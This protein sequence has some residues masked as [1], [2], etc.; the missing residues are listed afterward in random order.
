MPQFPG[1]SQLSC[2]HCWPQVTQLTVPQNLNPSPPG[3][4]S[5]ASISGEYIID[6]F[7]TMHTLS[8][9]TGWKF[10]TTFLNGT[11]ICLSPALDSR[12]Q[13]KQFSLTFFTFSVQNASIVLLFILYYNIND[14][15][16]EYL[17]KAIFRLFQLCNLS[18]VGYKSESWKEPV[19][20]DVLC[21]SSSVV[22]LSVGRHCKQIPTLVLFT[23]M[24]MTLD[25][26]FTK[27]TLLIR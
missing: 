10:K 2:G 15:Y 1:F 4:R 19:Y 11:I 12:E 16:Q 5:R 24:T 7:T 6:C 3:T 14:I 17:L 26:S 27:K 20:S 18:N 9:L 23:L 8:Y 13:F 21:A 22:L 25:S